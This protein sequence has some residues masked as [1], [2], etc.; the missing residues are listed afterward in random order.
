MIR[1]IGIGIL[2]AFFFSSTFVFNRAMSLA[3]GS[4][5]WT[6][7]LRY[8]D[9]LLLLAGWLLVTGQ[10]GQLRAIFGAFRRHWRFWCVA[11]SVGFGTFYALLTFSSCYAPGW[12]VATTWQATIL[13]TPVVLLVFGRKVP[14]RGI[15]FTALI[16]AG[17]VSVT[18]EQAGSVSGR[19]L[20]LGIVP[21]IAAAFAY[22][23]GNQLVW[24][25][26]HGD[27]R[28]IPR[29][30]D[31]AADSSVGRVLLMVLGS[32]PFWI[33][34]ILLSRPG[35]PSRGQ[36]VNTLMVALFS[37]VIA[38]TLFFRARHLARTPMELAA[39]DATQ[40]TEVLFS[41]LG[42]I[43]FLQGAVPGAA[44]CAGITLCVTGLVLYIRS[45]SSAGEQ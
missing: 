9:T 36:L 29:I 26:R 17:I 15:C 27:G 45:Q 12:V 4:W 38:T 34:L 3:G 5:V 7:S 24:E 16:F 30:D 39:V 1:L 37:G 35:V 10:G 44:G 31:P 2:S 43:V 22:P 28:L 25:A 41:L 32:I 40:S 33:L 20:L 19:G 21:V 42:E 23:L 18:I 13:A 11:G 8:F 14:L 6:A